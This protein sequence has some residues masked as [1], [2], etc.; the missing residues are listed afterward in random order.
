[1]SASATL[2]FHP[3]SLWQPVPQQKGTVSNPADFLPPFNNAQE[4]IGV[5][6]LFSRAYLAGTNRTRKLKSQSIFT[7]ILI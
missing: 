3:M 7:R 4:Q 1:M 6:A 2:P 5:D